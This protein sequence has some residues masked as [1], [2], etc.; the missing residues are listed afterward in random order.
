[1]RVR[2]PLARTAHAA[3][4]TRAGAA[5][6]CALAA[7]LTAGCTVGTPFEEYSSRTG[8]PTTQAAPSDDEIV[9]GSI[10]PAST[11]PLDSVLAA[12][13]HAAVLTALG[14]ALD[15]QS[16]GAPV[17]WTAAGGQGRG[18]ARPT[19]MAKPLGD[20]ICRPFALDGAGISGKFTAKG[21][22][23]RNKRGDWRV[24]ELTT[25]KDA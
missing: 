15:P 5:A 1:M 20:D 8:A 19:A 21:L 23:C 4:T 24:T 7:M 11:N 17:T 6:A 12:A 9:T 2:T 25:G 16:P 18:E 14:A 13:D 3:V 22:A 10:K